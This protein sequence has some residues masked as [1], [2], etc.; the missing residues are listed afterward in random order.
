MSLLEKQ[1]V[2]VTVRRSMGSD[3]DGACGQLRRKVGKPFDHVSQFSCALLAVILACYHRILKDYT[4][5]RDIDG[6]CGQLRR[7]V[8][9]NEDD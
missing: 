8:I 3:I 4:T 7:K 2:S 9:K 6:A 1:G 5:P